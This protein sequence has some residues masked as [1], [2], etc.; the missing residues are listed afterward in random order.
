MTRPGS[1]A[2]I[3]A[4]EARVALRELAA[5]LGGGRRR[6]AVFAVVG[7]VLFT[8]MLHGF[9]VGLV[10]PDVETWRT[11]TLG[12][13]VAVTGTG[14]LSFA[15]MISQAL[16]AVT[17]AF[18]G[19]A[20]LDLILSSPFNPARLFGVRLAAIAAITA[21]MAL[22]FVGPFFNVLALTASV[23]WLC[24]YVVV[25]AMAAAASALA[26]LLAVGL[27]QTLGP[28]R[29]RTVSQIL[30][31]VIGA[32][33]VIG[34]QVIGIVSYGT[35]SRL[36]FL[37]SES[38]LAAAPPLESALW[39]PVRAMMGEGEPLSW[40]VAIGLG[41]FLLAAALVAPRV[42]RFASETAGAAAPMRGATGGAAAFR[43]ASP[44][45]SLRRKEWR[46]LRR[47]P[48]LISQTLMQLLY[49]IPPAVLLWRNFGA[50]VD[51]VVVIA[52]VLVMAAGQLGGGLAWLSVSG[53]DAP[54]LV[55]T[56]PIR[57]RDATAAKIQA[58]AA[59]VGA[60]FAPFLLALLAIS[61]LGATTTAASV[62]G[63]VAAA[64]L[65]QLWFRVAA[66]RSQFRRRQTASRVATFAE[67]FSSVGWAA[68][69][70][71]AAAQSWIVAAFA[72]L[73][74]LGVL[75]AARAMSPGL[76]DSAGGDKNAKLATAAVSS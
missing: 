51:G 30:S 48:W 1:L 28:R 9:A 16:E 74:T 62:I 13:L 57:S 38:L 5:M 54:E 25:A 35:M 24:G 6:R 15:L 32:A 50:G 4:H 71:F 23:G 3:A 75:A 67:A 41:M 20:D 72:T 14:L 42:A 53:E 64:T 34:A 70:G 12:F 44:M 21:A 26:A 69:A 10:A 49:L 55:A 56:A 22:A 19:R 18:Y 31:A 73:A 63:A 43:P 76:G 40:V 58:V 37:Q 59:V 27:F 39:W 8:L 52:P 61:P 33:F 17:R 36:A 65:I 29:T 66:K 11:P 47:D 68:V 46:L 2:W 60:I 7:A 45:Q